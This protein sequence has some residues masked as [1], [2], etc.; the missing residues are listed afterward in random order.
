MFLEERFPLKIRY[1]SSKDRRYAVDV[2]TDA[3][4]NAYPMLR[5]PYVIARYEADFSPKFIAE[6]NELASLFDRCGGMFGGFR[7]KD[8]TDYTTNNWTDAPTY[9]DQLCTT[10]SAATGTYQLTRWY[11][12]EG[13]S[14]AARRRIR[15]PVAGT[16]AVGIRDAAAND[17]QITAFT[18]DT[19]T[20]IV[21]L[22]ANKTDTIAGI[23]QAA[24][25]VVDVGTNTFAIG[26][27]VHFSGV[28][29]MTQINGMRGQVTAKPDST[30][31]TVNINTTGFSAYS[32]GG[33]LNTRPQTGETV[34]AGCE[35]DI[36]CRFENDLTG[37]THTDYSLMATTVALVEWL[38]PA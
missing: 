30:H 9:H 14:T 37:M 6:M 33:T 3:A 25:A 35:F 28:V 10:I 27:S 15:K 20:G 31:I 21:T 24:S 11:A 1:G 4:D 32:S 23:T 2:V 36:P 12:T 16:V 13:G 19:T 29:G 5:H 17:H 18:V 34:R 8:I 7:V 38:N 22:S 26:D